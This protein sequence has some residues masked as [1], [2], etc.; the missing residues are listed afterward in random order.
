[1]HI[2]CIARLLHNCTMGVRDFFKA[3]DDVVATIKAAVIKNKDRKNGF[4][5]AGLPSSPV[6]VITRWATW[7]RAAIYTAKTFLLFVPLSTSEQV[8]VS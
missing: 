6:S 3:I 5:E 8:K 7:L 4:C 1:M 2:T